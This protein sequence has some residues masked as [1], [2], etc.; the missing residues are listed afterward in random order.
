M[1]TEESRLTPS[2]P[3]R[4]RDTVT[5]I[6]VPGLVQQLYFHFL[7]QSNEYPYGGMV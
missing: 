2:A 1:H 3:R 6:P 7:C 5:T 4:Y